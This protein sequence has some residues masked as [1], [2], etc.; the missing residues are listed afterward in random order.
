MELLE[1][2]SAW[3]ALDDLV[4]HKDHVNEKVISESMHS[5]SKAEIASIRSNLQLKFTIAGLSVIAAISLSILAFINPAYNPLDFAFSQKESTICFLFMAFAISAMFIFNYQAYN[6]IKVIQESAY[7]LKTNLEAF[8]KSMKRAIN[9]NIWSDTFMTPIFVT[10]IYYA[11]AFKNHS[12]TFD[13]RGIMLLIIPLLVGTLSFLLQS[14]M[15]GLKFG[16]YLHR[17]Q[18]YLD[19]LKKNSDD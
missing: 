4:I 2:K 15:Q 9:F 13:N 10:W 12:L 1:L 8:I 7:D 16:N 6:K 3:N 18:S 19:S 11:Y 14:Y 17:L 5:K